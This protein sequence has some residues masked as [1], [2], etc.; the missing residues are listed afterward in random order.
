VI[1]LLLGAASWA[2]GFEVAQQSA[3]AGGTGHAGTARRDEAAS[4][5]LNPAALA[6]GE[7]FRSALGVAVA[8]SSIRSASLPDSPGP[9]WESTTDNALGTPPHLYLSFAHADWVVG[10]AGNTPFAGGVRWPE[11]W[12]QR[13]DIISSQPRFFRVAPFVGYR[14]G[15][16]RL[17]GGVH[18]DIGGLDV[19]KATDHIDEEGEARIR[20]DGH[21]VG[22]DAALFVDLSDAV[23]V[24]LCYKSRTDVHLE[25]EADFTVPAAFSSRYPDQL[26]EADWT[27]PDRV[28]LGL[29]ATRGP[30]T[31]LGDLGLTLWS[32]ND[33]LVFDFAEEGTDDIVQANDWRNSLA[34]RLGAEWRSERWTARAGGYVDGI[35]GAP[36]PA[37]T[38][39]PSSPDST[40]LG[41]TLGGRFC[42]HER[43]AVDVFGEHL[44]LLR[45][46]S[47][48]LDAPVA[49]YWGWATVGG[50]GITLRQ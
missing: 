22:G 48:S 6:D 31:V 44:R 20:V 5:W 30:V 33:E 43:F 28:V 13:F 11:D 39:S 2:G 38:L 4:A 40:R 35:P 29:A 27:L 12:S 3:V 19:H 10:L 37:E 15:R 1:W 7:G 21:G 23:S 42:P 46:D 47:E 16:V 36:P 8:S 17:S 49:G 24:G 9:T 34:L 41:L 18:V 45:R 26:V 14:L 32:V 25:G 50:V